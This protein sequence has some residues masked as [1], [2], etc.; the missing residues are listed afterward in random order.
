MLRRQNQQHSL[1][2]LLPQEQVIRK[3]NLVVIFVLK[4][5]RFGHE[6]HVL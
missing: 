1:L 5:L 6:F 3:P 2:L 4:E